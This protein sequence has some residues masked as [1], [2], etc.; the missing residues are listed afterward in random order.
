MGNVSTIQP[1]H[2]VS[3][4]LTKQ[5]RSDQK[6]GPFGSLIMNKKHVNSID[7]PQHYPCVLLFA[8]QKV[9]SILR[10]RRRH[11]KKRKRDRR[12][13]S[14][15]REETTWKREK[16]IMTFLLPP[17]LFTAR[18]A[19]VPPITR[20]MTRPTRQRKIWQ[21]PGQVVDPPPRRGGLNS[22]IVQGR[23]TTSREAGISSRKPCCTRRLSTK[24]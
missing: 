19:L 3:E 5:E 12:R 22:R 15:R 2:E 16:Y 21:Q 10:S 18:L 17:R 23:A 9:S 4:S 8:C 7:I 11:E 20:L 13:D 14:G 6:V 1:V 24:E